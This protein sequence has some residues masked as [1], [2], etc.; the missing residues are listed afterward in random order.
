MKNHT[1]TNNKRSITMQKK[2]QQPM[3]RVWIELDQP[4]SEEHAQRLVAAANA[5]MFKLGAEEPVFEWL[6]D[7]REFI[8]LLPGSAGFIYLVDRGEWFNLERL[9]AVSNT[10]EA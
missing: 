8:R 4:E 1:I 6:S 2:D 3:C 9:A 7:K 5:M 10:E